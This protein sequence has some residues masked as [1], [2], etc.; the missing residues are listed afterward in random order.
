MIR[1]RSPQDF[2][3][4]LCTILIAALALWEIRDLRTGTI[5]R[6]GPGYIPLVLASIVAGLGIIITVSAF[7]LDGKPLERWAWR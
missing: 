4:G 5:F 6:M 1:L 3:A 7:A 2:V